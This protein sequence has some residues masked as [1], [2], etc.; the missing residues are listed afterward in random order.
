[1]SYRTEQ[2]RNIALAGHPGAGKTELFEAL[3]H[4]GGAIAQP[5]SIA[6]GSTVSDVDALEKQ[7][8]HLLDAAIAS[9][10]HAGI[11]VNLIDT[12]FVRISAGP[13]CVRWRRWKPCAWWW[14]ATAASAMARGACCNTC[15][16]AACAGPS[17][18]TRSTMRPTWAGCWRTCAVPS[19]RRCCRRICPRPRAAFRP[20]RRACGCVPA[21]PPR[22]DRPA[23]WCRPAGRVRPRRSCAGCGA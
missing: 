17:W 1:M 10:D 16:T 7:R 19:G 4:A 14:M 6:R 22:P 23:C 2:I 9:T 5:G 13:R 3:L 15:R 11:H 12:P 18:S 21:R 8:G 20:A